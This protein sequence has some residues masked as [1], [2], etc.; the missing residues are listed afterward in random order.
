MKTLTKKS[1]ICV[2]IAI[3]MILNIIP[4]GS[5]S[6]VYGVD[7]VPNVTIASDG[8][9]SWNAV[10]GENVLYGFGIVEANC[11]SALQAET[12]G[13]IDYYMT[14]NSNPAGVYTVSVTAYGDNGNTVLATTNVLVS[15]N[16]TTYDTHNIVLTE[17]FVT[18]RFITG[19]N[20]TISG[21]YDFVLTAGMEVTNGLTINGPKVTVMD[22]GI[23]V[24][25]GNLTI[26]NT[27]I[28]VS[29]HT[30]GRAIN[31][32]SGSIT[33][34][35]CSVNINITNQ[36]TYC[37]YGDNGVT[38]TN[39]I[40][41][42]KADVNNGGYGIYSYAG[43]VSL[44]GGELTHEGYGTGIDAYRGKVTIDS[45][46]VTIDS[47]Y[48]DAI[49]SGRGDLTFIN[50]QVIANGG[51]EK[52]L[53]GGQMSGLWSYDNII[54]NGGYVLASSIYGDGIYANDNIE[55]K[56]GTIKVEAKG[57]TR[58]MEATKILWDS[59][60]SLTTP[61]GGRFDELA[62]SIVKKD[63][64]NADYVVIE[65]NDKDIKNLSIKL[66]KTSYTYNG[67][68]PKPTVTVKDKSGNV[69]S[70]SNYDVTYSKGCKNVGEY[71]VS[72]K[73]KGSYEG[74]KKLTYKINPKGTSISKLTPASKAF[75][76]KWGK[77]A[78]QVTG[79]EIMYSTSSKFESGNKT[80]KVKSYKTVSKKISKLKAKKKYYVKVR[81]YKTVNGKKYCSG[82]SKVKKVTTKK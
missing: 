14:L 51:K 38:S 32:E 69:I 3:A 21:P 33:I 62:E 11:Y 31:V 58:G 75:T 4:F 28:S 26:K 17:G 19:D 41:D 47:S 73:F 30:Y 46:K 40:Y 81:T 55:I 2:I 15:Y 49:S 79:Y 77:Q 35:D 10:S 78:V 24:K 67:K 70:K 76:A 72:V 25:S 39:S 74:T 45:V 18:S 12:N 16:G 64:T 36:A 61:A 59:S 13:D 27:N 23:N 71:T 44:T 9:I 42:L 5:I 53:V 65:S 60:L 57:A 6:K 54:V 68:V 37:M 20:L 34:E 63:G 82:W 80:V 66:S 56:K 50:S 8:K 43:D 48:S 29:R 22:P 7:T 1:L 52:R